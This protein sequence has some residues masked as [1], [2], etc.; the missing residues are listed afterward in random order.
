MLPAA[1]AQEWTSLAAAAAQEPAWRQPAARPQAV[2][3]KQCLGFTCDSPPRK[4]PHAQN[5][6]SCDPTG[7]LQEGRRQSA[8]NVL[9]SFA[10]PKRQQKTPPDCP[11]ARLLARQEGALNSSPASV[12]AAVAVFFALMLCL[13]STRDSPSQKQVSTCTRHG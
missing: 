3:N 7:N 1:A 11:K 8:T 10:C 5:T 13:G 2:S 12:A 4:L 9:I 6:A